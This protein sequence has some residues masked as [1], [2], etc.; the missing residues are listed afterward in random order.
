MDAPDDNEPRTSLMISSFDDLLQAARSQPTAQ[1]LLLV[2]AAAELPEDADDAQRT[3]YAAGQGGALVPMMCVDKAAEELTSFS[4]L[5][6]EAQQFGK[7]WAM[8]FAAALS[9]QGAHPPSS[10]EAAPLL[11][12][13]VEAIQRGDIAAYI[14]FNPQGEA[15]QLG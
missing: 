4:A 12:R 3:L 1:R 2:F 15:V 6:D 13:M 9:G 11:Q 5:A 8:V 7:P 14:P 10:E